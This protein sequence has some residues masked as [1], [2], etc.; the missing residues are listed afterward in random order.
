MTTEAPRSRSLSR[1]QIIRVVAA[2]LLVSGIT[3]YAL[4]AHFSNPPTGKYDPVI[5]Q[6]A[7]GKLDGDSIGRVDLSRAFQGLTPKD[8]MFIT[9]RTDGS[10]LAFFPTYYGPGIC[11]AG[12]L[13]TSR[14][15]QDADTYSIQLASALDR[16][17]IDVGAWPRLTMDKKLDENW[18]TVSRGLH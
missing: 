12:V 14:P 17:M 15:L 11:I 6:L 5:E 4:W 16:R 8:E 2:V 10:F 3:S 1:L 13:Y 9:R 18:F 7:S